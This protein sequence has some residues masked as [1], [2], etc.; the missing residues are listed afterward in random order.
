MLSFPF[1]SSGIIIQYKGYHV[2]FLLL[3]ATQSSDGAS[4]RVRKYKLCL[5]LCDTRDCSPPGSSIHGIF[6][7]RI[8]EWVAISFSR[9]SSQP[10]DQTWVSCMGGGFFTVWAMR[11]A[12][13]RSTTPTVTAEDLGEYKNQP[14]MT[15]TF[16][17]GEQGNRLG[18]RQP[19]CI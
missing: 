5:T 6:Q 18:P 16:P 8:L 12:K 11:T 9:G 17:E 3:K 1:T 19:R 10:W 4:F 14:S 15:S 2:M 13:F 7:A